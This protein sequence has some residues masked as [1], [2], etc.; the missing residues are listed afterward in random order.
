[1]PIEMISPARYENA[2]RIFPPKG[3][4]YFEEKRFFNFQRKT[5]NHENIAE[6]VNF[7]NKNEHRKMDWDNRKKTYE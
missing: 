4:W 1:M 5:R 3:K 7:I 6:E 2:G